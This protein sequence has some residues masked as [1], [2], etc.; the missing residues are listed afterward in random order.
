MGKTGLWHSGNSY[1]SSSMSKRMDQNYLLNKQYR[2]AT[3]LQARISLHNRF[4][5]NPYDW[6][7]FVFDHLNLPDDAAILEL[8]CG[9]GNLWEKN[10]ARIPPRWTITLSDFSPG[11]LSDARKNLAHTNR[12]FQYRI[13]DAQQIPLDDEHLDA[14][15]ANHMLYHIPNRQQALSEIHRVLKRRGF[16]FAATNGANHLSELHALYEL[17]HPTMLHS[18]NHTFSANEFT[19]DN[20]LHQLTPWFHAEIFHY[21]DALVITETDPLI[22]YLLSMAPLDDLIISE[23]NIAQLR[24]K[25]EKRLRNEGSIYITKSTGLFVCQKKDL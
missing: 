25:I 1:L 22:A 20:G 16:L 10:L 11:M 18:I 23:E 9:L 15:V 13:I 6:F 7:H 5:T 24:S 17:L 12:M 21:E 19:L 4:K 2:D 8:G 3:N 14:I